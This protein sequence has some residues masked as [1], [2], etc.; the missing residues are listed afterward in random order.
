MKTQ[1][2]TLT[3]YQTLDRIY[4]GTRTLV[5]RARSLSDKQPVAIKVLRSEYPSFTELVQFRNQYTIAKNLNLPGIIETYSLETYQNSYA[6]VMEDFGG[7]SLKEW[8]Q[9]GETA[10]NLSELLQMAIDISSTLDILCRHRIIHKDIKPANILINPQTKQVK[11]IDFSIASLLPRETQILMNPNVL[12]G[13]LGYLSPEQTGRMNRGID[14]RTDFYSLGV[15]FYELLAGELPFQSNDAMELVHCHIAKQPP[16]LHDIN[17][18]IPQVLSE[19]VN[20]LMAKNAEDRYQSALGL[21]FDLEFCLRQLQESG[22]IYDFEIAQRDLCDRFIIPEKLY[23]RETEVKTLLEAFER[24]ASPLTK[25]EHRGVEMM[26]VAGFSGIG[27]TVVVNEVHKPIVRQRGYFIKGKFDQFNR[28]IPFSAFVQ[29]FR[30]LMGQLLSES[31]SQLNIWKTKILEVVGDNGQVLVDVIP[32]LELIIGKQPPATELSGTSAQ[33]RFNLLIQNFIK[34][35]T[36]QE[37]PLVMFIDDLQW[38]DSASQNLLKLLMQDT[39]YLLVLGAYRD[40]EVSPVH[41]F[42]LTVDE[43]IKTGAVVQTITLQP[44]SLEDTNQ[45]VADTLNC[46]LSLAQPLTKL[47]YQKTKGNPFFATQFLKALHDDELIS[48]NWDIRHWQCD[49]AKVRAWALTDDV[50]EFMA[51]QLQKLPTETQDML[52]L[53]ACIGAKFDLHTLM[54]VS[55]KSAGMTAT[56]LWKALQEELV[57]PTTKIYKFFTQAEGEAAFETAAN[58][59]YC[60]LHDRV[61]QAAYSL[62]PEDQQQSTHLAMARL[63]RQNTPDAELESNIFEIVNHWNR[64][65]ALLVDPLEKTNLAQLNLMAGNRA[66]AANAYEPALTYCSTGLALLD[67]L[68]GWQNQTSLMLALHEGAAAAAY[69]FGDFAQMEQ[70]VS[71]ILAQKLETLDLVKTYEIQ[72]QAHSTQSQFLEAIAIAQ[73]ALE[74][75]NIHLPKQPAPADIVPAMQE[76]AELLNG[77]TADDLLDLP[78][79]TD[80]E[81][82]ASM[83]L[84]SSIIATSYVS[85]PLLF[86]FVVLAQVKLSIQLGNTALSAFTYTTYAVLLSS[87]LED[88]DPAY[89]FGQLGLKLAEK[90]KLP[91]VQTKVNVIVGAFT[92]H[93]KSH[94]QNSLPL[95]TE[96]FKIGLEVGDFEY[97]G[98]GA[99]HICQSS[100]AVGKELT[101]LLTEIEIYIAT[102]LKLKVIGI[103]NYS[104]AILQTIQRLQATRNEAALTAQ[105]ELHNTLTVS[106]DLSGLHFYWVYRLTASYLLNEMV[107]AKQDAAQARQTLAAGAGLIGVPIFYFY[108]SLTALADFLEVTD[109]TAVLDRVAENQTKLHHRAYHAPM[110]FQHKYDLVEA[111][112][113]RVLG[114]KVEAIEYYDRAISGA[115]ENGFIQ[116]EALANEL[117]AKFLLAWG[118]I[119]IAAGYMQEAYYCYARW[120]AKAKIDDL[121]KRYPQL[122]APILQAKQN[123]SALSE[124]SRKTINKSSILDQTIQTTQSSSSSISEALDFDTIFKASQAVSSE[125]ELEKLQAALMSVL[126]ENAGATKAVLL[127]V[128]DGNLAV[129][130]VASL[131]ENV[132]SMSVPLSASEE[133]PAAAVNYV[134]RTLTTVVL[135][136]AAAQNDFMAEPYL[137]EQ[138]PKSLLCAPILHQGKLI[139][140]LYLENNLTIGAFTGDRTQVIQL[141]CAQ[142]AISLE[143]ARLYQQSQAYARD[144][145][146]SLVDLQQAQ[147]QLVQSEKMS[148]L[149]NLIAGVAHEI[150]NPVGFISGNIDEATNTIA[151]V[152]NHLK[153]YQEKL[154]NPGEEIE[155]D[156][157]DI[158]LEYALEDLPKMLS[159]MKVGCDR[160]RGISTSLRIFSRADKD[161]KVPFNI[162]EGIDST[163]LILKHRLKANEHRPAI[164]VVTDY[165]NL[166]QIECFPGQLNQVFMNLLSNAIDAL[167][168]SSQGRSF[169]QIEANPNCI[170]VRSALESDRHILIAIAD[171]GAGMTETVKQR[172]FDHLFTTKAVGK[173]TGL[174]LAIARQIIVEKHGGNITVNSTPGQSTEFIIT[175]P[176]YAG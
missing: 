175:L 157:E 55:E 163:I 118:K 16:S 139:G 47:V 17:P 59:T 94:L 115:K 127:L 80:A 151:D 74:Q 148:A 133:V 73:N 45:L 153:L 144:L 85:A 122:L 20:K 147:L 65:I 2:F 84:L 62:I 111:E 10:P 91:P 79:M 75:F 117:A 8:T 95:L 104:L 26:L 3:G 107:E 90:F 31:D 39:K 81:A 38:S 37:H 116:E 135:D 167:D 126:L 165:G 93:C 76:V 89:E 33:N 11:L 166:P 41:P 124:T 36:S 21:K 143:N 137:M 15:T 12:E 7:I 120:G 49:I 14:Y 58:P 152:I 128:K 131:K 112:R 108:D 149:G 174:G 52:K 63:L 40:N 48:F 13:T 42:I 1:N 83:Q 129:E 92:I 109:K 125:I 100:Y 123:R 46:E 97:T 162:H 106:N 19:I 9:Q 142:A 25:E 56:Y 141:L 150:N 87:I 158:D 161:Y 98:Y 53:A 96:A 57:I 70:W 60:F 146:R 105:K 138:K 64:A 24:V 113:S 23:G 140:L 43:I 171:N 168:E 136:N 170:A 72:I 114:N 134:K 159:S 67:D 160:I 145:E 132:I 50:V 32:E 28:N 71:A 29:A 155:Q 18:Q 5:Y 66:K 77:R 156:A 6:L 4:L 164:E 101:T 102:L 88:L 173:G 121:E 78:V 154:P 176:I 69:L 110:N 82:L 130:A 86:P 54:I 61:Q 44:L 27:K 34:V 35:F 169:A 22:T 172:I 119:K 99:A 51:L 68:G 30:D 103:S